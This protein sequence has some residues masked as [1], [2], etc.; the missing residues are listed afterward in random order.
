MLITYS[1]AI[2]SR[3]SDQKVLLRWVLIKDPRGGA[4]FVH[5]PKRFGRR[6]HRGF[7]ATMACGSDF[8]G[9]TPIPRAGNPAAVVGPGGRAKDAAAIGTQVSNLPTGQAPICNPKDQ[10]GNHSLVPKECLYLLDDP[11]CST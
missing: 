11:S 3:R 7:C 8:C 1:D 5:G 6:H 4:I 9:G 10:V 2:W